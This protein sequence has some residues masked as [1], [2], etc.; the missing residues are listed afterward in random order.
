MNQFKLKAYKVSKW[1]N[2]ILTL[3]GWTAIIAGII[4]GDVTLGLELNE[5][6]FKEEKAK[7]MGLGGVI[8]ISS[9]III[10]ALRQISGT[11]KIFLSEQLV[12]IKSRDDQN[13]FVGSNVDGVE[14]NFENLQTD[15]LKDVPEKIEESLKF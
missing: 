1:T 11:I 4:F 10:I 7:C 14:A 15:A 8:C 6:I 9:V 3:L 12:V 2:L 5:L 13:N